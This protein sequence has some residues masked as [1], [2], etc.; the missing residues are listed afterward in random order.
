MASWVSV[1]S[2]YLLFR[3]RM[4]FQS[5]VGL[6]L[7]FMP[8]INCFHFSLCSCLMSLSIS[9]FSVLMRSM[10]SGVGNCDLSLLRTFILCLMFLLNVGLKWRMLPAGTNLLLASVMMLLMCFV[11]VSML[12]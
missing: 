4:S 3:L 8:S 7:K 11:A 1:L 5:L 9:L 6:V 12:L 2:V 10:M